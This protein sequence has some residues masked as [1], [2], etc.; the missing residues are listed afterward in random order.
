M[1]LMFRL[2]HSTVRTKF[3]WIA[4]RRSDVGRSEVVAF[5]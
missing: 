5:E 3:R 1:L 4:L 2:V